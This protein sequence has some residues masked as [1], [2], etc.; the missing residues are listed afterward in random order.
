MI[1]ISTE[2]SKKVKNSVDKLNSPIILLGITSQ[3][4]T[5]NFSVACEDKHSII[6][7]NFISRGAC[8]ANCK[9]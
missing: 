4:G 7:I 1:C 6:H 8:Y 3:C 9:N 5:T 2:H